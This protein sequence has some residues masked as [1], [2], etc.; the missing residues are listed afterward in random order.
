MVSDMVTNMELDMVA[1]MEVGKVTD[2]VAG[3]VTDNNK[4]W[5]WPWWLTRWLTLWPTWSWTGWPKAR[6]GGVQGGWHSG[7]HV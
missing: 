4:K 3:M 2:K 6:H 1:D 5:N 7:R